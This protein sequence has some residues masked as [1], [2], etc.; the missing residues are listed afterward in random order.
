MSP[1][2]T[3]DTIHVCNVQVNRRIRDELNQSVLLSC[4]ELHNT[5]H[6]TCVRGVYQ[7]RSNILTSQLQ[8]QHNPRTS[9]GPCVDCTYFEVSASH[10]RQAN[11]GLFN[12]RVLVSPQYSMPSLHYHARIFG[13]SQ[14]CQS[15]FIN[16]SNSFS[17]MTSS[18]SKRS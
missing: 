9:Q 13:E 2:I 16:S 14:C 3:V 5:V 6:S 1:R 4:N 8:I 18:T 15:D 17:Y 12:R 11:Q 10:N 7:T